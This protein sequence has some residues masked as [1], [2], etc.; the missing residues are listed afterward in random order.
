M[1]RVICGNDCSRFEKRP[2]WFWKTTAVVFA[3]GGAFFFKFADGVGR[4]CLQIGHCDAALRPWHR[5][6]SVGG[7]WRKRWWV[8]AQASVGFGASVGGFWRKRWWVAAKPSM[9]CGEK[10]FY[11]NI[12]WYAKNSVSLPLM[13]HAACRAGHGMEND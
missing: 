13:P 5:G 10:F 2:Q 4:Q 1:G 6:A 7:F 3:N 12:L 8:L 9:P 11:E